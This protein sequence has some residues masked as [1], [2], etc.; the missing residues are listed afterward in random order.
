MARKTKSLR[1]QPFIR[2]GH[3]INLNHYPWGAK[4]DSDRADKFCRMFRRVHDLFEEGAANV[5]WVFCPMRRGISNSL[6]LAAYYP[7]DAYADRLGLDGY[8]WAGAR[9][10]P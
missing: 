5:E 3:E 1:R 10:R 9:N 2:R 4:S 7:G 8:N 6:P